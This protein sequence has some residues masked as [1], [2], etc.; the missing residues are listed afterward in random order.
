MTLDQLR[1]FIAVAEREHVTRA[2]EVLNLTQSAV[3]AA[4]HALESRHDVVLFDRVG[5]RIELTAAGRLFLLE[6]RS[7]LERARAAEAA[8]DDLGDLKRG[9]VS[10]SASQTIASYWLP[11][12]LVRFRERFTG[13]DIRLRVGTT[14]T[15]VRDVIEGTSEV[16][17]IEGPVDEPATER[18]R[19]GG[20][21]LVIIVGA[22]HPWFGDESVQA[23]QL[24][25]TSWY[26][27]EAGSGTRDA[28]NSSLLDLGIDAGKLN[29]TLELPTNNAVRAAV[30]AGEA[31]A[32]LSHLVVE[33]A[34][35]LGTLF[36]LHIELPERD[37]FLL[38]HRERV[39][40][41]AAKAFVES[42]LHASPVKQRSSARSADTKRA[43][44]VT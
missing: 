13:I 44:P 2:A 1:I 31:A 36:R 12:R 18:Q 16:G 29:V 35:A 10:V 41:K 17:F 19:I 3:S 14:A 6:A 26:C 25:T 34:L 4:I 20:D 40:T 11:T 32:G 15:V 23:D 22:G 27:R 5:R 21:R 8:L 33:D 38:Q 39:R 7:V 43:R 28:F 24:E 9:V 37:F 42:M 30:I